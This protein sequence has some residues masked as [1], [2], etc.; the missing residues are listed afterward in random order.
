[1]RS[2]RRI[3]AVLVVAGLAAAAT[4]NAQTVRPPPDRGAAMLEDLMNIRHLK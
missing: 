4:A 3:Q 2:T 1:M